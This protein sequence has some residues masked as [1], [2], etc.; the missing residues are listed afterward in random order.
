VAKDGKEITDPDQKSKLMKRGKSIWINDSYWLVMPFKLKD[1][2]VTLNYV[3]EDTISTGE[4]ADVLEMK[5]KNVGVTPQNKYEVFVTKDDNLIKQ[6]A[7][8]YTL[9]FKKV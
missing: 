3:R 4:K 5:F 6:W 9:N 1:S 7:F 8:L 2:G